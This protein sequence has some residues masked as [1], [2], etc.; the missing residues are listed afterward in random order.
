MPFWDDLETFS[1]EKFAA[2]VAE[3]DDLHKL[4]TP[5]VSPYEEF[6]GIPVIWPM[7]QARSINA[8]VGDDEITISNNTAK[9]Y[10][11]LFSL[12]NVV[13]MKVSYTDTSVNTGLGT[14][15]EAV[16]KVPRTYSDTWYNYRRTSPETL[17][18]IDVPK[19][20]LIL[21]TTSMRQRYSDTVSGKFCDMASLC[22]W[23]DKGNPLWATFNVASLFQDI[24]LGALSVE[25]SAYMPKDMGGYGKSLPF[26]NPEN[27]IRFHKAFKNGQY[28]ELSKVIVRNVNSYMVNPIKGPDQVPEILR[29]ITQLEPIFQDWI[30][31]H[32]AFIKAL[33]IEIPSELWTHRVAQITTDAVESQLAGRL[34]AEKALVS[35]TQLKVHLNH[36]SWAKALISSETWEQTKELIKE[37]KVDWKTVD[38]FS[39][40]T[41]GV[42][43]R[44][45][46]FSDPTDLREDEVKDFVCYLKETRDFRKSLQRE[47]LYHPDVLKDIYIKG[48]MLIKEFELFPRIITINKQITSHSDQK[49]VKDTQEMHATQK[50]L[51]WFLGDRKDPPPRDIVNDDDFIIKEAQRVNNPRY[52]IAVVTDD[53]KLFKKIAYKL[54]KK[55]L[56]VP[57][58]MAISIMYFGDKPLEEFLPN[59]SNWVLI[60][61]SGSFDSGTERYFREG[62]FYPFGAVT[63]DASFFR[64]WSL[65]IVIEDLN[66]EQAAIDSV[67]IP[68]NWPWAFRITPSVARPVNRSRGS[69]LK[70]K[71]GIYT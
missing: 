27:F 9:P 38:T 20:R 26:D 54:G 59:D 65:P 16:L 22:S 47:W 3:D 55:V 13:D 34:L 15:A 60:T 68:K 36:N 66:N 49:D 37:F 1:P 33:D 5:N 58:V 50:A 42:L 29:H 2:L 46:I 48:P 44:L 24:V 30:K 69:W 40:E 11:K 8:D 19:I 70:E 41:L 51:E 57:V 39:M 64:H 25:T 6:T 23:V 7:G 21:H 62:Y 31:G 71:H 63:K 12:E 67:F 14:Y 61:D 17:G 18:Y 45:A 43:K 35:E 32:G 56:R 53:V 28:F 52:G 4:G 10:Y